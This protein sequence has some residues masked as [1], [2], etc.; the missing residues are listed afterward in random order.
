MNSYGVEVGKCYMFRSVTMYYTGKIVEVHVDKNG[1]DWRYVLEKA[2]W[3]ADTGRWADYL[4]DP[5]GIAREVEPYPVE[6]KPFV[7]AAGML[8]VVEIEEGQLPLRQK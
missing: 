7:Y 1:Q 8:D 4:K 3:I 6:C 2:A 5:S